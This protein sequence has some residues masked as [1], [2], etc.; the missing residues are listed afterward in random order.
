MVNRGPDRIERH[1]A[2]WHEGRGAW[3]VARAKSVGLCVPVGERV[4]R[5]H[6]GGWTSV[7]CDREGG[8]DG[9]GHAR[10]SGS[11]A[12]IRVVRKCVF[13]ASRDGGRWAPAKI[14]ECESEVQGLAV[15]ILV[16]DSNAVHERLKRRIGRSNAVADVVRSIRCCCTEGHSGREPAACVVMR[17]TGVIGEGEAV[18]RGKDS[19][20]LVVD[21]NRRGLHVFQR[22]WHRRA[23]VGALLVE[24]EGEVCVA[25]SAER[26]DVHFEEVRRGIRARIWAS[27]GGVDLVVHDRGV[28]KGRRRDQCVDCRRYSAARSSRDAGVEDRVADVGAVT[29]DVR[30][31]G[32][33][34]SDLFESDVTGHRCTCG[35]GDSDDEEGENGGNERE[36]DSRSVVLCRLL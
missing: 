19:V 20:G 25:A 9:C 24:G 5:S 18:Q 14:L 21:V 15:R 22:D 28:H 17:E 35:L 16:A 11:R 23:R 1:V 12:T 30:R 6:E 36:R 29:D 4:V 3:C 10:R 2:S 8:T 34:E 26:G 31:G 7:R 27:G 13:S 33:V 32:V